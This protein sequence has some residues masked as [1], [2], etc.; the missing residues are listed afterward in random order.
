MYK[1][2][3][4]AAPRLAEDQL[5][6]ADGNT[7][8]IIDTVLYADGLAAPYTKEFA[9]TLRGGDL[10]TTCRN[11]WEFVKKQIPYKLDESGYQW[12]KSPGRLWKDKGGDCKS[13][14]V[15]TASCLKNLGIKYGYR[16]SS[17]RTDPTPTH[18]YVYVPNGKGQEIILDSVW[19]GPFNTEKKY[20]HKKD[21]LMSEIHYLG[22]IGGRITPAKYAQ[23]GHVPGE[24]KFT[25]PIDQI[26]EGEMDLLL[27]RQRLEIEKANSIGIAGPNNFQVKKYDAALETINRALG[28]I[29]NPDIISGMGEAMVRNAMANGQYPMVG[30]IFKKIGKGIKKGFKAIT[31]VVTAPLR[32]IAKGALEIYLPKAA[33]AFLYLFAQENVLTDKMRAKRRKSEKFKNFIV[34][35]IGMKDKHFMSIIRNKLTKSY[36][37]SPENYLAKKLQAVAVKGIGNL[38]NRKRIVNGQKY[39][40]PHVGAFPVAVIIAAVNWIIGKLGGKKEGISLESADIPDLEADSANALNF[41]TLQGD[42][43]NLTQTQQYQVKDV[44]T[45]LINDNANDYMVQQ[46]IRTQLPYLNQAQQQEI[47]YQVQQGFDPIDQQQA[48]QMGRQIKQDVIDPTGQDIEK[49]ERTGGGTGPGLCK[50]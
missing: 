14:S 31:K 16:F 10:K 49:F 2:H 17:Y 26:T 30:N 34:K 47:N 25:K 48:Y 13:F 40:N 41:P 45:E 19:D 24:L 21:Y 23:H 32:L 36:G 39:K 38:Q 29:H 8:D 43:R 46:Q 18:V 3:L 4:I 27:A 12:V 9:Q 1:T 37:M 50:C 7:Q 20:T 5:K 33:P 44:A 6:H 22:S 42:Y 15:F 35:K 28:N 11:I